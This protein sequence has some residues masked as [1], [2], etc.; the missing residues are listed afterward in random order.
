MEEYSWKPHGVCLAQKG[1]SQASIYGYMR[2]QQRRTVSS[3]SRCQAARF[4]QYSAYLSRT[5]SAKSRGKVSTGSPRPEVPPRTVA[6]NRHTACMFS[7]FKL[8]SLPTSGPFLHQI[9]R[10]AQARNRRAARRGVAAEGEEN[11]I[12]YNMI[13][14]V[15]I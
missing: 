7:N 1:L 2:E 8:E 10:A 3:N 12:Y 15:M 13:L 9:P 14:W 5:L 6:L 4:Q 11:I